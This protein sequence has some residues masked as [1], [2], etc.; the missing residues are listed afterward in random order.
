MDY[1]FKK[2]REIFGEIKNTL[3]LCTRKSKKE[4]P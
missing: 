4:A 3:Y 2:V 1:F